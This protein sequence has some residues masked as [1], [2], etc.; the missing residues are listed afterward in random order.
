MTIDE[1]TTY[2]GILTATDPESDALTFV[3][4][5]DPAHGTISIDANGNFSYIPTANYQGSDTFTYSVDDGENVP[6]TQ[7]VSITISD[8]AE[9]NEAPSP[10]FTTLTMDEDTSHSGTLTATDP[11]SDALTFAKVTDPAHGTLSID[12]NGNFSYTPTANYQGSDTFTYSVNDGTNTAV[13]Q[14]VTITITDVA[15]PDN[16]APVI[17][18]SGASSITL[19]VGDSYTELGATAQDDRDGDISSDIIM[20]GAVDTS[21]AGTYTVRYN[22]QD[23]AGNDAIEVR[24]TVVVEEAEVV[25]EAPFNLSIS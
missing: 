3:K 6:V 4:V 13:T 19:T 12:A 20:T 15:E 2:S 1:D 21:T 8:I 17:T 5:T 7:V 23:A 11:E 24:R 25:N 10:T 9:P 14:I 16:T 18:L 22:V